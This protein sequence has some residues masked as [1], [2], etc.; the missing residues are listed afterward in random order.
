MFSC[1]STTGRSLTGNPLSVGMAAAT[2][3]LVFN[4]GDDYNTATPVSEEYEAYS[5]YNYHT[6]DI[7]ARNVP[8]ASGGEE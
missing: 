1:A 6:E 4:D 3:R 2:W 5:T 7:E 8:L